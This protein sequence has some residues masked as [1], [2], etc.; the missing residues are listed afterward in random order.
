MMFWIFMAVMSL[1]I[2]LTM[3]IFG[4]LFVNKAPDDINFVF[5]YRSSMSMKNRLTWEFAHKTVGRIWYRAG[6]VMMP[7]SL[8][9]MIFMADRDVDTVG[10]FGGGL[11]IIQCVVMVLTI[12][13]VEKALK[14][15]FNENGVPKE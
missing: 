9:A 11:V 5:G 10:W 13:P 12:F 1:I 15:K 8:A 6:I 3:I 2:P 4:R 7:L 14:E